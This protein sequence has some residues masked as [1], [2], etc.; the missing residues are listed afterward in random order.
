[1]LVRAKISFAG[2]FSMHQSEVKECDD[3]AVLQD[4]FKAGYIEE[5]TQDKP[6]TKGGKTNESK[7]N[8][9]K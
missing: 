1:M 4:L 5:V 9:N 7:R 8:S 2:T 6:T 3:K